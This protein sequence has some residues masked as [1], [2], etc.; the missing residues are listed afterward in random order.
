MLR[1]GIVADGCANCGARKAFIWP[2]LRLRGPCAERD[3]FTLL[4]QVVNVSEMGIE[5]LPKQHDVSNT[6]SALATIET[7][8]AGDLGKAFSVVAFRSEVVSDSIRL[9]PEKRSRS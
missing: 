9:T 4:E 3:D 1:K 2:F 6:S 7:S 8:R 5:D